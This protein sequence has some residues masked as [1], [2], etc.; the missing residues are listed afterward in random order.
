VM[1]LSM[2]HS[3]PGPLS[4]FSPTNAT[5]DLLRQFE[6]MNSFLTRTDSTL[7]KNNTALDKLHEQL[8]KPL[9]VN[10]YGHNGISEA[11]DDISRFKRLT[12]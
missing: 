2:N 1:N 8:K 6:K 9:S 11:L 12:Q 7:R 10:K 3:S 5:G 4:S